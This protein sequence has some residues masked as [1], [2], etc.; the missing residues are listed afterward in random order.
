M[1]LQAST[2]GQQDDHAATADQRSQG[3]DRE[4][5][6]NLDTDLMNN[7]HLNVEDMQHI[8]EEETEQTQAT[9][10]SVGM[11]CIWLPTIDLM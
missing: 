8:E 10:M 6:T 1:M 9:M 7:D 2:F 4:L 5:Q 11:N 3:S